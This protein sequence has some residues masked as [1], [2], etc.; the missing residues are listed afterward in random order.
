MIHVIT[1]LLTLLFSMSSPAMEM[2]A[3]F[4]QSSLA[5]EGTTALQP[6]A[7]AAFQT[8]TT[9]TLA[10]YELGGNAGLVGNTYNVN[11]WGLYQTSAPQG[12]FALVNALKAEAS[13]AGATQ[14]SITGNALTPLSTLRGLTPGMAGRLGLELTRAALST[15]GR[16]GSKFLSLDWVRM[17]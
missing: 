14:I 13:A 15:G 16:A 12:P 11:L 5:A 8:G 17:P 4:W 7:E 10:G 6:M 1:C 2:N 9:R 3:D